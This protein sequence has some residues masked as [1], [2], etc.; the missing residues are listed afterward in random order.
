MDEHPLDGMRILVTRPEGQAGVTSHLVR[1]LGAEP[2]ELPLIAIG[3][4]PDPALVTEALRTLD[5]YDCITFT[6]ENAVARVFMEIA[7]QGRGAE[8]FRR[9]RIAA[10]GRGTASLLAFHG[11]RA[12]I[13]PREFV[14]ESLAQAILGNAAIQALLPSNQPRVL[15]F[16]ALNAREVVP[17]RLR[18]QGCFVDTIPAYATSQASK[19]R[20]VEFISMLETRALDC[21]LLTSSS[22]ADGLADLLGTRA[23]TLLQNVVLACIGPITTATAEGQGFTVGFSAVDCTVAGLL[24]ELKP[25]FAEHRELASGLRARRSGPS[26]FQ[27]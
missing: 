26:P 19:A 15:V 6:S 22:A 8:V 23:S 14:G 10:I 11:V 24:H 20:R 5:Q 9:S 25:Y 13:V 2:V 1:C 18:E 12:D 7:A 16:R 17:D 21:I 4:P 3:P 27:L